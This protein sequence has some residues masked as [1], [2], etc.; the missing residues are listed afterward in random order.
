MEITKAIKCRSCGGAMYSDQ[1]T[2]SYLCPFCSSKVPWD[3]DNYY[4]T[5]PIYFRHKPVARLDGYLKLGHVEIPQSVWSGELLKEQRLRLRGVDDL[6]AD[7]DQTTHTAFANAYLVKFSCPNCGAAIQ[8]ESTQSIFACIYC[9]N[10]LGSEQ[11]LKPGAYR[12]ELI[13]GVGAQ[14]LADQALPFHVGPDQAMRAVAELV[15]AYPSDFAGQEM[16]RRMREELTA[17]YLPCELAD[18]SIKAQVK[19]EKGTV[20]LYQ[21]IINWARPQT[22]L[23]DGHLLDR[24]DPWDFG[25]IGNFDPAFLEGN[26]RIASRMNE[27]LEDSSITQRIILR[28]LPDD[29]KNSFGV[30]KAEIVQWSTDLRGHKYAYMMVPIYYID[31]RPSDGKDTLQ[32]RI[33]V[34]GQTGKVTALFLK[35]EE[36][37]YYRTFEPPQ[38]KAFSS[39]STVRTKL[40]PVRYVKPPFLH[41]TLRFEK[42]LERKGFSG[43]F[44]R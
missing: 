23:Y 5:L 28:R 33:A 11:A 41:E 20:R 3:E 35:G 44:K 7:M 17:V 2:A 31:K 32:V 8:G 9:G 25:D 12:K 13:M 43:L 19:T 14:N 22:P 26:V 16:E 34:N 29:V 37:E 42:A 38:A 24:L 10:K 39:E 40:V 27:I 36:L 15:C 18:L 30:K 21:E 4:R 1:K 6:L